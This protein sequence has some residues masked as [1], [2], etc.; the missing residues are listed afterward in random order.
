MVPGIKAQTRQW[1]QQM[2]PGIKAHRVCELQSH[3]ILPV[4]NMLIRS[5]GGPNETYHVLTF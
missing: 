3:Q 1:Y 4:G 5:E 2:V